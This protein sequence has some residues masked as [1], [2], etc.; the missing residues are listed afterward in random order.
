MPDHPA[1]LYPIVKQACVLASA[2]LRVRKS[3]EMARGNVN[4]QLILADLL[5]GVASPLVEGPVAEWRIAP[6]KG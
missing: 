3:H 4:P 5:N 2:I 1:L 6:A